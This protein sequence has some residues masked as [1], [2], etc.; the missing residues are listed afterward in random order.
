MACRT[1]QLVG[2]AAAVLL[3]VGTAGADLLLSWQYT[4]PGVLASGH[5][6][7]LPLA[8]YGSQY[9]PYDYYVT[10]FNGER[11]GQAISGLVPTSSPGA[12]SYYSTGDSYRF[13]Y[14]NRVTWGG[15]SAPFLNNAGI[16]YTAP[17][18]A[19]GGHPAGAPN[20]GA[21]N[22]YLENGHYTEA[23]HTGYNQFETIQADGQLTTPEPAT[24]VLFLGPLVLLVARSF[25]RRVPG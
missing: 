16:L 19:S 6:T 15:P 22:I 24:W 13:E 10:S 4:G 1:Q 23:Y 14:D 3:V 7:A 11:N 2:L 25:R 5:L 18:P 8:P 12:R 21:V 9:G 17:L 20:P